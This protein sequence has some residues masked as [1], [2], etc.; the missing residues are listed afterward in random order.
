MRSS[1]SIN[2]KAAKARARRKRYEKTR[3]L[4]ANV[5]TEKTVERE[6]RFR[7]V[8]IR[9]GGP[10]IFIQGRPKLE[11]DGYR[12]K[13]VKRRIYNNPDP[14]DKTRPA[15]DEYG[16]DIGMARYTKRRKERAPKAAQVSK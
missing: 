16:R 3:N 14:M 8:R 7:Q 9:E 5:P 2:R 10:V 13:V 15:I 12:Q 11:H 1:R 4:N 6:A